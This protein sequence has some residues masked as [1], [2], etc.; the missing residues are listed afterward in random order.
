[1]KLL[2]I[3][4][5][6]EEYGGEYVSWKNNHEIHLVFEGESDLDIF[7]PYAHKELFFELAKKEKWIIV[8]NPVADY[9][10]VCH[11]FTI[12]KELKIYHLHV[13]FKVITGESWLKEYNFPLDD[14]LIENRILHP[15]G[16]YILNKKAQA[17]LFVLRHFLKGYSL[18]SRILY[19]NE[20]S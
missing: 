8:K 17:Y 20:L 6:F 12:D 14:F 2:E 18:S 7:I 13:Y 9:P 16:I 5:S 11:L 19:K 10:N 15:S 1:M 4:H 3:L